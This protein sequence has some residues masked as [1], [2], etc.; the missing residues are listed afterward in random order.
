M[1]RDT[2]RILDT[3][4]LKVGQDVYMRSGQRGEWG[5]VVD[6][7]PTGAI[8]QSDPYLGCDELIRFDKNGVACDSSDIDVRRYKHLVLFR[9]VKVPAPCDRDFDLDRLD[10]VVAQAPGVSKLTRSIAGIS[11]DN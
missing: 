6:V 1:N 3:T 5:T 9:D 8:V 10:S 4:K 7:T 2:N 11:I